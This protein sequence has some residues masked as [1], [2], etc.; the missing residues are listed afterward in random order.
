[1]CINVG[2]GK[3]FRLLIGLVVL[4]SILCAQSLTTGDIAGVVKDP[5]GGI[6]QGATVVLKSLDTGST[7]DSTTD[8]TGAYRFRLLKPGRYT[9]AASQAG[10]Q[11]T[12]QNVEVS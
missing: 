8:S 3:L 1:M 7:Q 2:S 12:E 10:F 6:V 5:S 4:A 11:K 9:V